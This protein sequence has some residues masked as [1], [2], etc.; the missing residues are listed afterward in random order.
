MA[1]RGFGGMNLVSAVNRITAKMALAVN[2]RGYVDSGWTL[3]SLLTNAI[4]TVSDAIQTISRLNDSTP[5]G[6]AG[7]F[8]YVVKGA[9]GNLYNGTA[10]TLTAIATGM[11]ANPVSLVPFRPNTSV[12]PFDYVGDDAPDGN[13]TITTK[14]VID[15][16][17]ATFVCS[18]MVKVSSTGQIYKMGI[19]EPQSAPVVSTAGTTT[20][21]TDSLPATTIP[22]T[23]VGGVNPSYNYGQTSGA[24][25]TAPVVISTPA[26]AQTLTLAVTGSATVNGATHAPGDTG[27]TGSSFPANFTGAGPKIVLG[28]FT[29]GSGNV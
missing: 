22:W 15:G 26:G 13:V 4:L 23:N 8:S 18:G 21:G 3:R 29:D 27:P 9:G 1:K 7:G 17:P 5:A 2:V 6:P 24:D 16:S 11:S 12:R 19:K 14:K 25:G 28:A 20:T 10:G